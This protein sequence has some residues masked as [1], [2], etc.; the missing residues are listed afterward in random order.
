TLIEPYVTQKGNLYH[1]DLYRLS[2]PE[3]LEW[4]GIRDL[5]DGENICLV[6]WPERGVGMLPDPDLNI[7]LAVHD[8]GR[9][10]LVEPASRRGE[11]MLG[12]CQR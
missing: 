5:F 10:I 9:K 11:Q 12:C 2:D 6:E 7:H 4:I 3:E 1:L 8:D